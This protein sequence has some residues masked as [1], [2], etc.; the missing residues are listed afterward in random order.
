[1]PVR[2]NEA[3]YHGASAEVVASALRLRLPGDLLAVPDSHDAFVFRQDSLG[4]QPGFIHREDIA[5]EIMGLS[6]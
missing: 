4:F 6:H 5:V 3:R 1:M 2:I